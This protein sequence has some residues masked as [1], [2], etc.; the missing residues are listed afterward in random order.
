MTKVSDFLT[1]SERSQIEELKGKIGNSEDKKELAV[2]TQEADAILVQAEKRAELKDSLGPLSIKQTM[3]PNVV[4]EFE[5]VLL[6]LRG[7]F[8]VDQLKIKLQTLHEMVQESEIEYLE[9]KLK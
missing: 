5:G 4:E 8:D 2:Y 3:T 6:N 1:K 9:R 7:V